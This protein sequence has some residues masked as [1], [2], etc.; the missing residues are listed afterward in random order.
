MLIDRQA[1]PGAVPLLLLWLSGS[2]IPAPWSC[3]DGQQCRQVPL[4]LLAQLE[5]CGKNLFI[6]KGNFSTA[7]FAQGFDLKTLSD[8]TGCGQ[9][10][11]PLSFCAGKTLETCKQVSLT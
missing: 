3:S 1:S 5:P 6:A 8:I 11:S 2:G 7:W 4:A 9:A 10:A